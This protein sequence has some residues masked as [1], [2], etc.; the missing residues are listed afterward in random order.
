MKAL[1]VIAHPDDHVLWING[2][3]SRFRNWEWHIL[4]LC[5]SHNDKFQPKLE[6][7]NKSCD[8]LGA[9]KYQARRLKDYQTKG[10]MEIE[11]PSK[12]QKEIL[13]FA[14][15]EYDLIF[16]HSVDPNCE[17]GFHANHSE[18]RDSVVGLIDE[19]LLKTKAVLYFCYKAQ[20]Q[21]KPVIANL[22]GADYK[23]ELN[24]EEA[25]KKKQ[26][27]QFFTWAEGDLKG[28]ALWD[29]EE[30]KIEAFN[31]RYFSKIELPEGFIKCKN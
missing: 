31:I 15:K 18:V 5:N 25:K 28:L 22:G 17:Y 9:K 12:M 6:T 10:L 3:I 29:N 16:T 1:V 4:S 23:I 2:T 7:F 13:A 19:K 24:R 30:P 27:K 8:N 14:D 11:Q 20:G 21:K 26:L